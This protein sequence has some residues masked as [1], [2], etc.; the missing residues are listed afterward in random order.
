MERVRSHIM[1]CGGTGC[2]SAESEALIDALKLELKNVNYEK[3]VNVI[4]TGCFGFCGQ[5]PIV[6]IHPDN[7]FYV[8]VTK[9]DAHE[10]ISEHIVKGRPVS[11][12]LFVD[13]EKQ[14]RLD[15]EDQMAFYKKTVQDRFT[16][17]W[18]D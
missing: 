13:P 15:R 18:F 11:R 12:L 2:I 3:E 14:K 6:K 10:I 8:K 9:E 1:V 7:T 16:Q 5:G 4:R 17:L